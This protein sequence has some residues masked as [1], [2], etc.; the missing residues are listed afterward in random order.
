MKDFTCVTRSERQGAGAE[1]ILDFW[2]EEGHTFEYSF[3]FRRDRIYVSQV[4]DKIDLS[5]PYDE[6]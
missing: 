4:S 1:I 5:E 2:C 3:D 6:F